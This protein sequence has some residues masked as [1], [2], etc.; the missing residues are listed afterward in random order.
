MSFRKIIHFI[1]YNNLTVFIV[2]A[3][4]LASAGVFAQTP[5]GQDLIGVQAKKVEGI[6]NTLLLQADLDNFNQ[7]YK[8]EKIEEDNNYYYVTYTYLDLVRDENAWQ[9]QIQEKIKKVSKKLK[10][11]LGVFLAEQFLQEYQAK[12]KDLR[13]AKA[14]AEETGSEKRVEVVVYT[15]LIGQT[16]DLVSKV[17]PTYQPIKKYEVPSPTVPPTVLQLADDKEAGTTATA[18]NLTNVYNDYV[19]EN[20]PDSDNIFGSLDNCPSIFNPDQKDSD[21]DGSGDL[22]LTIAAR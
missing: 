12:I 9:Y 17:F 14:K 16:L 4:F 3:I 18:D 21:N 15:G 19:K 6:D 1:Q 2:L 20:D 7:D 13:D 5:T 22:R 10:K 11:D 8:I